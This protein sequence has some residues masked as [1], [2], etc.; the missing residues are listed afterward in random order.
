MVNTSF[1][2]KRKLTSVLLEFSLLLTMKTDSLYLLL[3]EAAAAHSIYLLNPCQFI[4]Y[5]ENTSSEMP[6]YDTQ[7]K[8]EDIC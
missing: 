1:P 2:L 5:P 6:N 4:T 3:H 7:T 8:S